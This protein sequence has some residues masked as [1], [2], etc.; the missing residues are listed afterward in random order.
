MY[1][2]KI[3]IY[4]LKLQVIEPD[5][6]CKHKVM[7]LLIFGPKISSKIDRKQGLEIE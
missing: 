1:G 2:Y 3:A 7:S 4:E 5:L 6:N